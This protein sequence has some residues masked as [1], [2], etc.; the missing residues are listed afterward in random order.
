VLDCRSSVGR[1]VARSSGPVLVPP[2]RVLG[3]PAA[4]RLSSGALRPAYA[5][6]TLEEG[7]TASQALR[8]PPGRWEISL[9]YLGSMSLRVQ[10]GERSVT[11]PPNQE[12]PGPW[13]RVAE[14]EGGRDVPVTITADRMPAL[15][16]RRT[17]AIGNVAAVRLDAPARWLPPLRACGRYVDAYAPA[18]P[19]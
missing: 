6:D 19:R 9:Q 17:A 1:R 12:L 18:S 15:E 7:Q 10:A 11:L 14:V 4:W 5:P 3:D 16:V 13:W 2:A 8:L